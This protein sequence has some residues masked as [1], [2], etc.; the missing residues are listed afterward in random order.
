MYLFVFTIKKGV[1]S[2]LRGRV[3]LSVHL[4]VSFCGRS[5]ETTAD[6][7]TVELG[8]V[9]KNHADLHQQHRH[10]SENH[11]RLRAKIVTEHDTVF[12]CV[13]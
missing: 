7:F 12:S 5:V 11:T 4:S 13:Q 9:L 6:V 1:Y 10:Y 8:K 3:Y 2:I